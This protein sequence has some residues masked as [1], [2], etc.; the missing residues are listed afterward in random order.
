MWTEEAPT[1]GT[2]TFVMADDD[3]PANEIGWYNYNGVDWVYI[4]AS[5]NHNDLQS[6]DGGGAGE[7]YHLTLAQ[8]TIA[9]QS[10]TAA[11]DGYL[12][13]ANWTTFNNKAP[14]ANPTFTGTVTVPDSS[15]TY[16]KLQDASANVVLGRTGTAG[17]VEEI[18]CTA[19][20]RSILD[21][22]TTAD[23]RTTIGL[24][25]VTN[26]SK[27]T[28][29]TNPTFTGTVTGVSKAMVGLGSCDNTSDLAKP[30]STATIAA[31]ALKANIASP[32]FTGTPAAPTAAP[33]T[34][35][36]QIATTAFVQAAIGA[37]GVYLTLTDGVDTFRIMVRSG[38]FCL[39]QTITPTGF[40]GVEDTDWA[41]ISAQQL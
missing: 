30:L 9:T 39:D 18:T 33:G 8:H 4:G 2:T 16:A 5:S 14:T 21:D 36:T 27:A 29:F 6:I 17:E 1:S 41:N 13:Q 19:V 34:N 35:T 11:R 24:G 28:M 40:A 23:V 20:G 31:L 10:A 38:Y 25:N 37:G 7:Y 26:E 15:F 22:A 12:T 32:T 3:V